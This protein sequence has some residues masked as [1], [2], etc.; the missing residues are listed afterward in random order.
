MI[1]L[2]RQADH[3]QMVLAHLSRFVGLTNFEMI[4]RLACTSATV[5]S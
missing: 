4:G 1:E 3:V 2:V 5:C